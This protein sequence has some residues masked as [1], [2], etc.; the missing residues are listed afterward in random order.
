M[1]ETEAETIRLWIGGLDLAGDD[2]SIRD[3]ALDLVDDY[4]RLR[5]A[6]EPWPVEAD[7]APSVVIPIS[8]EAYERYEQTGEVPEPSVIDLAGDFMAHVAIAAVASAF[9]SGMRLAARISGRR[10]A[11]RVLGL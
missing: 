8:E 10:L 2:A 4:M 7:P 11:D 3:G 1:G 6:Y 9:A 5:A